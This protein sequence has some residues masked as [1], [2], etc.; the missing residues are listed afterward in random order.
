MKQMTTGETRM[1]LSYSAISTYLNCPLKYKFRYID[2]LPV[3]A[4]SALQFGNA[5]HKTLHRLYSKNEPLDKLLVSLKSHWREEPLGSEKDTNYSLD[6]A[7]RILS[8][9]YNKNFSPDYQEAG[10]AIALEEWFEIDFDGHT[11]CGRIDRIDTLPDGGH[12]IIDYKTN[13]RMP[14]QSDI[15]K[16]LQL[17][18]YYW[19]AHEA[20]EDVDPRKLTLHFLRQNIPIFTKR[21]EDS[22]KAVKKTVIKIIDD[23][24]R[25]KKGTFEPTKNPLCGWCDYQNECANNS[26]T[27][28]EGVFISQSLFDV[29]TDDSKSFKE[30]EINQKEVIHLVDE[31]IDL[32]NQEIT[33]KERLFEI[34]AMLNKIFLQHDTSELSSKKGTILRSP[35]GKLKIK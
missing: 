20:I 25:D 21:N 19:A 16:D 13:K 2:K 7:E 26:K 23:I 1:R 18:I 22:I 31:Y 27:E 14:R 34:Q 30:S 29:T 35:G 12:E 9:Y 5:L 8:N 3:E 10:N 11:L 24:Q 33:V 28:Q 17:S 6:V 15:D 32:K 4:S